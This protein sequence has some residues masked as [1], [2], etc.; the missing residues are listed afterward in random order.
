MI[1]LLLINTFCGL[2]LTGLIWFV[3]VV[4]YPLFHKVGVS[5]F[6]GYEKAHM[7]LTSF[8]VIPLM[9]GELVSALLLPFLNNDSVPQAAP[10]AY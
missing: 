5:G 7:R 10:A 3:Q 6:S 9:L 8:V 2:M 1:E 4:H